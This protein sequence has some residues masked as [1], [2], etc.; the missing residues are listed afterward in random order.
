MINEPISKDN[1]VQTW[2]RENRADSGGV[3]RHQEGVRGSHPDGERP[4]IPGG[5]V[6]YPQHPLEV[7]GQ[8][9]EGCRLVLIIVSNFY[10]NYEY[11]SLLKYW[12][13]NAKWFIRVQML[14]SDSVHVDVLKVK[15]ITANYRYISQSIMC[16]MVC[17]II[18]LTVILK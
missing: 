18:I 12:W 11:L 3:H 5:V 7:A 14:D 15:S 8:L 1:S 10:I 4:V 9:Q 17:Q 13:P 6:R 16:K 2:P